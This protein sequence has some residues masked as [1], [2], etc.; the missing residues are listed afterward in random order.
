MSITAACSQCGKAIKAPDDAAGK[1]GKCPACGAAI[2]IPAAS[3]AASAGPSAAADNDPMAALAAALGAAAGGSSPAEP[4]AVAPGQP[5]EIASPLAAEL[6]APTPVRPSPVPIA[7]A[8]PAAAKGPTSDPA[9]TAAGPNVDSDV[10]A[11]PPI[12]VQTPSGLP[13]P[14]GP[15]LTHAWQRRLAGYVRIVGL[16]LAGLSFACG[17]T[18]MILMA[19]QGRNMLMMGIGLFVVLFVVAAMSALGGLLLRHVLLLLA[20]LGQ[21]VRS[22][23]DLLDRISERLG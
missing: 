9:A 22:L 19:Q 18:T 21:G 2:E 17:V 1:K 16:A 8:K 5:A 13:R 12:G 4:A 11:V 14:Y 6:L 7:A 20:D 23:E 3:G 15:G 10:I